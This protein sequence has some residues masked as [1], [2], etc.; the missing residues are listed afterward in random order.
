MSTRIAPNP[1]SPYADAN[2]SL[3]HLFTSLL[4]F[5]HP[6]PGVLAPAACG[7]MAVVPADRLNLTPESDL[8]DGLCPACVAEMRGEH[9]PLSIPPAECRECE[10][11]TRHADLCALCRQEKHD[12]WWTTRRTTEEAGQ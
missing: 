10:S 2:P 7:G 6:A 8:P 3:R 1:Y 4:F 5:P 11:D 12:V 9:T